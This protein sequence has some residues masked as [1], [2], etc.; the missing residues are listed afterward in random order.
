[1]SNFDPGKL[2]TAFT[3]RLEELATAG[4]FDEDCFLTA[5]L[6]IEK[7]F[8]VRLEQCRV[9]TDAFAAA[10]Q[11]ATRGTPLLTDR[12]KYIEW[13]DRIFDPAEALGWWTGAKKNI[14]ES[15]NDSRATDQSAEAV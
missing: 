12:E 8:S 1:M 5:C 14:Q 10:W 2:V 6:W 13:G 3:E 15:L 9:T 11:D 4:V 7:P